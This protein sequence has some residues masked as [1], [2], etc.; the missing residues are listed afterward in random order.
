MYPL[1]ISKLPFLM[2]KKHVEASHGAP[3]S[4]AHFNNSKVPK[5]AIDEHV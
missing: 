2:A 5:K 4:L 3:C 1:N